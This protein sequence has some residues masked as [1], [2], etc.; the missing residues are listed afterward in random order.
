MNELPEER[1]WKV[2]VRDEIK[3]IFE[4]KEDMMTKRAKPLRSC[5]LPSEHLARA[6]H[7]PLKEQFWI[8]Y[9]MLFNCTLCLYI[10]MYISMFSFTSYVSLIV[11]LRS[12]I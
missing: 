5:F 9:K 7:F 6:C 3:H 11:V 2:R 10:I 8:V 12:V 4:V 1:E